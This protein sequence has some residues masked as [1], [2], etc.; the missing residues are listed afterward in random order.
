MDYIFF[1]YCFL[2]RFS[3]FF[4]TWRAWR[5]RLNE[6]DIFV[7]WLKNILSKKHYIFANCTTDK[8]SKQTRKISGFYP[9][10]FLT[11][12][13][14]NPSRQ[15]WYIITTQSCISLPH[16]CGV[17]HH[18]FR[19]VLKI[20]RLDDIQ[21]FVLMICNSPRNW[22]N[23]MLRIDLWPLL[24]YGWGTIGTNNHFTLPFLSNL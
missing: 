10:L 23:T 16:K 9:V 14:K 7:C 11:R 13:P 4:T 19:C 17:Y 24:C 1:V 3:I 22:W 12:E 18:T 21:N 15:V 6:G 2:A 20:C 5:E 8:N